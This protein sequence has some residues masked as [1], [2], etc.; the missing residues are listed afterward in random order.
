MVFVFVFALVLDTLL[1]IFEAEVLLLLLLFL[2]LLLLLESL[3]FVSFKRLD[4]RSSVIGFSF[5]CSICERLGETGEF[6]GEG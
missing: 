1:P 3:R 4:M 5:L 2:L 6:E